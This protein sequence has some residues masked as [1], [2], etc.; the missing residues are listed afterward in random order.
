VETAWH[1][2]SR[3]QVFSG[4]VKSF[5]INWIIPTSVNQNQA[6]LNV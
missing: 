2:G 3:K 5:L 4:D 1:Q 6:D